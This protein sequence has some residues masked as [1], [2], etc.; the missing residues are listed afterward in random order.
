VE[1]CRIGNKKITF[2][3]IK[4]EKRLQEHSLAAGV[5]FHNGNTQL[6]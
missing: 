5:S 1:F 2:M 6:F 4:R 3:A